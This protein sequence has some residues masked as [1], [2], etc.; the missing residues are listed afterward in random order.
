MDYTSIY[1]TFKNSLK[2]TDWEPPTQYLDE[3][4]SIVS[5]IGE[6]SIPNEDAFADTLC[7]VISDKLGLYS[8]QIKALINTLAKHNCY[9][10]YQEKLVI[11]QGVVER[12]YNTLYKLVISKAIK[13]D[14]AK[15]ALDVKFFSNE[16]IMDSLSQ[17]LY[18]DEKRKDVIDSI[19]AC[20]VYR[21]F[22]KSLID[23]HYSNGL[24]SGRFYD[25]L[26]ARYPSKYDRSNALSILYVSKELYGTFKDYNSALASIL[27]YI[28]AD[29]SSLQNYCFSSIIID[30]IQEGDTS[31]TWRLYSDIV[32]YACKF[33]EEK[34]EIGYFHPSKI[35]DV[36]TRYINLL[37]ESKA[38][39][40]IANTG[41][42]YRDCIVVSN[43]TICKEGE[44]N[45]GGYKI[46]LI[47]QKNE[48]DEDVVP[49]PACKSTNVRGNSYPVLGVKSWECHNPLCPDK[50]KYNRG[51]RYSMSSI[52]KQEAIEDVRGQID[53]AFINDW[54]L[55]VVNPKTIEQV[56][57]YLVKEYSFV[58]D[59]IKLTNIHIDKDEFFLRKKKEQDF[60]ANCDTTCLSFF[61]SA[62]FE[63]FA[64]ESQTT[65]NNK[66]NS[67]LSDIEGIEIYNGN[68][69]EILAS[70]PSQTFDGAITSPPYYN[71]K[72]YSHWENIY[73]YLYDMYNH[74]RQVYRTLKD[75]AYYLYNIFD[76]F[77]NENN[78]VF[79]AM[80]Q[81]RMILGAYII[82]LF[83]KAGFEI[84]GNTIWYKGHIQGHRSTNQGNN[85]PYYQAPL[86]CYEHILCFRKSGCVSPKYEFPSIVNIYPVIKMIKGENVLG[87]SAPF[88][89][90]LP[91]IL[92][93]RM[94][95]GTILEPYAGSFTTARAARAKGVSSFSVEM[96]K[97]YCDLGI[98]LINQQE[99]TL[100]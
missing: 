70:V 83:R 79:S 35:K 90:A 37:D 67:N 43:E 72:D 89:T 75:G 88:P 54:R 73:C 81:S 49:C 85:S 69:E 99:Q 26:K 86:N 57:E 14:I 29:Y 31:I 59:T 9:F 47:F 95:G 25:F 5:S 87:H 50:S 3:F 63:R 6:P 74:A 55:D 66:Q 34:L 48:R 100:F 30:D 10:N 8:A 76:Y 13:K 82:Y 45:N 53:K 23:T 96:S 64:I 36:T 17:S 91:D 94:Q 51:K 78:I 32:L 61:S 60:I 41:F 93:S 84:Q 15:K 40:E 97:E 21:L 2:L 80:G 4:N 68:C 24:H 39:F 46:L 62:Y 38:R 65:V 52:I 56:A 19:F 22:D 44:E 1:T 98:K 92:L 58:N 7:V 12:D 16:E 33:I 20:L 77:D 71:A 18:D 11:Q 27:N 28:K 42:T